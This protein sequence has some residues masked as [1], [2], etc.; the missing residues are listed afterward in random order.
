MEYIKENYNLPQNDG[1]LSE[2]DITKT[3]YTIMWNTI[4]IMKA[5]NDKSLLLHE[6]TEPWFSALM[7]ITQ[8]EQGSLRE[9]FGE[10]ETIY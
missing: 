3:N 1:V 7:E 10:N 8:K 2:N 5:S 4:R 6:I 9:G